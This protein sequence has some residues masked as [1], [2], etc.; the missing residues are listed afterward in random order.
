MPSSPKTQN[1]AAQNT[2][3]SLNIQ[4]IA[5]G[6]AALS[7]VGLLLV[8]PFIYMMAALSLLGDVSP[9]NTQP[10]KIAFVAS[11]I[12]YALSIIYI[13]GVI[14]Y[15]RTAYRR[16]VQQVT[17]RSRDWLRLKLFSI[18]S[19]ATLL[20]LILV[21]TI[22]YRPFPGEGTLAVFT[23]STLTGT[24][25]LLLISYLLVLFSSVFLTLFNYLRKNK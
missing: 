24:D 9:N 8:V 16:A 23:P 14:V 20:V 18:S 4:V 2:N 3:T 17:Q 19:I 15:V 10:G 5:L 11:F 12:L 25:L 13:I 21:R 1:A 6:F 7:M 22:Q